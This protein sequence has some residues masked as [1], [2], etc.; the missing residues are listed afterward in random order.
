MNSKNIL[1][2]IIFIFLIVLFSCER[3]D[4]KKDMLIKTSTEVT[5]AMTE[6]WISGKIYDT[7]E[8][9]AEYGHCWSLEPNPTVDDQ[10]TIFYNG[11]TAV[12]EST[13]SGLSP[14]FWYYVRA[15][16]RDKD[17]VTVYSEREVDFIIENTWVQLPSFPGESRMGAFGFSINNTGYFGGGVR[18]Q[19]AT[20][21]SIND[22][23][24]YDPMNSVDNGWTKLSDYPGYSTYNTTFIINNKGYVFN[25]QTKS[26]YVYD[27][28]NNLWEEG[29]SLQDDNPRIAP[30]I[31][32]QDGI[33]YLLGGSNSNESYLYNPNLNEWYAWSDA[34]QSGGRQNAYG[35]QMNNRI[36]VG[37]GFDNSDNIYEPVIFREFYEYDF[38]YGIWISKANIIV[39]SFY[40]RTVALKDRGYIL[41]YDMMLVFDPAEGENGEWGQVEGFDSPRLFPA[42]INIGDIAYLLG[43]ATKGYEDLSTWLRTPNTIS[44]YLDWETLN[45]FWVYIPYADSE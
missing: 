39:K 9:V 17:S 19:G 21:V 28:E 44:D 23:W 11:D 15:Y 22:F 1:L 26:L 20:Q 43:G 25:G 14:H 2:N 6:A 29:A 12:F 8:G 31:F 33:A 3:L 34:F 13:L 37:G 45:D 18:R 7:G 38:Y 36:F 27:P 41:D 30:F 4:L 16:A 40:P 10:R 5:Y 32:V 42:L 24:E 35:F